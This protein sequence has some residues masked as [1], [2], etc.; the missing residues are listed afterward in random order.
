MD[1]RRVIEERLKKKEMEIQTLEDKLR[2][3]KI[4]VQALHDV[5]RLL[6]GAPASPGE[7]ESGQI[8]ETVPRSGS[9]VD[10]ARQVIL[11][12]G[13]PVHISPLLAALG[14]DISRESRA[15]LTSSLAAYVRRGEIFTRPAPN[16]FGLVEL[17]HDAV[18]DDEH[19]LPPSGFGSTTKPK[20]SHIPETNVETEHLTIDDDMTSTQL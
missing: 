18:A 4:Y 14:K 1:E 20:Q 7:T 8:S 12:T 2:S 13:S 17:G 5:L 3:A 10:Q 11:K 6:G 9:A 16:T 15:S 19:N